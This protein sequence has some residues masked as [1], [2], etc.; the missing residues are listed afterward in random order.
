MR[1]T[2]NDIV[3]KQ[4]TR[5][6]TGVSAGEVEDFLREVA[7][8]YE[9]T[10]ADSARLQQRMEEMERELERFEALESTLKEALVLAQATANETRAL[11]QREA[12]A[13]LRDA[14]VRADE[15][16]RDATWR[17]ESLRQERLRFGWEFRALLQSQ[18]DH[19]DA[20]LQR[21]ASPIEASHWPDSTPV[22][23]PL[24]A[25]GNSQSADLPLNAAA[26]PAEHSEPTPAEAANPLH[27]AD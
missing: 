3:N 10:I 23:G 17:S 26:G 13:V 5:S 25:N 9:Q 4:F 2:P 18:I 21:S 12:D 6:R 16:R 7:R 8:D 19:L 27:G 22:G 24:M 15:I 20:E 14:H 11:A 1:L